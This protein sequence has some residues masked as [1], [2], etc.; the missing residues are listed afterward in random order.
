MDKEFNIE[1]YMTGGVERIVKNALKASLSNPRESIFMAQYALASKKASEKR[2]IAEENGEHVVPFLIASITSS[3]N[4]HCAGCY[5]RANHACKD[6]APVDQMTAE[7][8]GNVFDEASELGV[9]FILLAGGE[10]FVR[11]DI[12]TRAADRPDILFPIFTNGTM[13]DDDYLK[14]FDRNR[15]LVPILSIEGG[16]ETTDN[17]RGQGVYQRLQTSMAKMKKAG[18][19]F[20]ASVTVTTENMQEVLSDDFVRQM[21]DKG[22]KAIIYVEFVPV[23]EEAKHLAPGDA[24]REFIKSKLYD[25]RMKHD[26]MVLISFPGDEKTSGGCLAAGRG[27]FHINSHG[28]AEPCPFSP[29]SDL[30]VKKVG[31][32]GALQSP[33][34]RGIQEQEL[35]MEDHAGGCVLFE[36]REQVEAL[37]K[38]A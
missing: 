17:R 31:L 25:L 24:E 14:L 27:F 20:G 35:L 26:D 36:R 4:L 23:T 1:R 37:M 34:F 12:I 11:R 8:W 18:V 6:T 28:G 3:C 16:E 15:N 30:N 22:A 9:G 5:S 7:E 33:L 10:P 13:V 32:K 29:Y 19:L 38:Q 2:R 21:Y